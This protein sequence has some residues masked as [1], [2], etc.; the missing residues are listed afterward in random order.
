ME[1]RYDK[2][3]LSFGLLFYH[4]MAMN[5]TLSH[6]PSRPLLAFTGQPHVLYC[7]ALQPQST[8]SAKSCLSQQACLILLAHRL[9]SLSF[10]AQLFHIGRLCHCTA[11]K[12]RE[13]RKASSDILLRQTF[14]AKD[15]SKDFTFLATVISETSL[16]SLLFNQ[17]TAHLL[18]IKLVIMIC[19]VRQVI[20]VSG[21]EL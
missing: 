17:P 14:F 13:I 11:E 16:S 3:C 18:R 9:P 5:L 7:S 10:T 4:V 2:V 6:C 1:Y 19:S 20:L 15:T 21:G 12:I 8:S